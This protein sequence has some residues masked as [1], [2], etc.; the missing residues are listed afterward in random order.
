MDK[1]IVDSVLDNSDHKK[2]I[3]KK[4]RW[5][6]FLALQSWPA[7]ELTFSIIKDL[8]IVYVYSVCT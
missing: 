3:D 1:C 2:R 5:G 7:S 6:V 8:F 4:G